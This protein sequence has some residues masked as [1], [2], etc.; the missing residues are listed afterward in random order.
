MALSAAARAALE[1]FRSQQQNPNGV[2]TVSEDAIDDQS[3]EGSAL[4]SL[5]GGAPS[6]MARPNGLRRPPSQNSNNDWNATSPVN[7]DRLT[8]GHNGLFRPEQ[9][10]TFKESGV[11]YR[12][13][14]SLILKTIKQ[15]GQMN[16]SQLAEHL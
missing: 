4:P 2:A 13:L 3:I 8:G 6:G 10:K 9:P 12:V 7:I 5:A 14:E 11:S 15:E 1:Q 16:E